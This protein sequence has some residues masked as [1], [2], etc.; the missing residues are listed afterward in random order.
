VFPFSLGVTGMVAHLISAIAKNLPP[1][2]VWST[3]IVT[4]KLCLT[5][6]M[7]VSHKPEVPNWRNSHKGEFKILVGIG[8][9]DWQ[10]FKLLEC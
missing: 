7:I 3:C 9:T 2:S 1:E 8:T 6:G 10:T 5:G 4:Q